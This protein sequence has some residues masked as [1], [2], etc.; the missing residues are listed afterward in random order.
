MACPPNRP[1]PKRSGDA[2]GKVA[3]GVTSEAAV[4]D[5]I[6]K[7]VRFLNMNWTA[8]LTSAATGFLE[9]AAAAGS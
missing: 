5:D 2:A 3:G 6:R 8:L 7:G 9:K 1:T 4:V